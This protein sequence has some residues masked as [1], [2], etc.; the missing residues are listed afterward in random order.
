MEKLNSNVVR[1]FD[2][3]SKKAEAPIISNEKLESQKKTAISDQI[4]FV[5]DKEKRIKDQIPVEYLD[6]DSGQR[7]EE[8]FEEAR[9]EEEIRK[10]FEN[11]QRLKESIKKDQEAKRKE[12]L[13]KKNAYLQ[14][15][16][17]N[18]VDQGAFK[19]SKNVQTNQRQVNRTRNS[20]GTISVVMPKLDL[21]P[22]GNGTGKRFT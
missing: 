10:E 21:S 14:P 6:K 2:D 22:K 11:D 15:K 3:K 16:K 20:N 17:K 1:V 9:R 7:L 5:I 12:E 13:T 8:S 19:G 18:L 4:E